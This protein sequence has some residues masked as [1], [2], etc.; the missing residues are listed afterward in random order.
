MPAVGKTLMAV[1]GSLLLDIGDRGSVLSV[2]RS[3]NLLV[4]APNCVMRAH[5]SYVRTP[6]RR[7]GLTVSSPPGA[8][9]C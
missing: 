9:T 4:S 6:P 8:L 5:T 7:Y 3:R 1:R 2:K